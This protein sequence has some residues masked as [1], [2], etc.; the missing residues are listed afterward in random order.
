[1]MAIA[2]FFGM[3]IVEVFSN[4]SEITTKLENGINEIFDFTERQFGY[5][6]AEGIDWVKSNISGILDAPV[7]ALQMG[8]FKGGQLLFGIFLAI[9]GCFFF[10][11][12]RSAYL[13]FVLQQIRP[14]VRKEWQSVAGQFQKVIRQ[15]LY[16]LGTVMLI[17]AIMNS[18]GLWLIGVDYPIF[19][20]TLAALLTVIPY[21]GTSIGGLLPFLYSMAT[22]DYFWQPI[23]VVVL[24]A[25]VQQIEGN[26]ITPNV[27]GSSVKINPLAAFLAV[28]IGGAIW[29]V[30]GIFLAL[31]I[32]AIIRIA[33]DHLPKLQPFGMLMGDDLRNGEDRFLKEWD[34]DEHR[35]FN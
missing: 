16:G 9:F 20:A 31:P 27:V 14:E 21:I 12:Y 5:S 25:S 33:F 22:Y 10:L 28:I 13:Q 19:W 26:L 7:E 8:I 18:I 3:Q 29:G 4:L 1:M 32:A 34:D 15:Y 17:L 35:F 2:Y 6:K 24:Y 30:A 11:Y 23:A